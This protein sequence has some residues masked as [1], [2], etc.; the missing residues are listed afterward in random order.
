MKNERDPEHYCF[1]GRLRALSKRIA[2]IFAVLVAI[3]GLAQAAEERSIF[4]TGLTTEC[5][6]FSVSPTGELLVFDTAKL[7][8]GTRLINLKTGAIQI[9]P[10]ESGRN[11]EMVRWASDGKRLVGIS[12]LV[13]DNNYIVEDQRVILIDPRDWS[14]RVIASGEGVKIFPFFS[15][16]DKRIYYFKGKARASGKTIAAGFDLFSVDV[17]SGREEKQTN[18]SFYQVSVG[19]AIKGGETILFSSFGG[20]NFMSQRNQYVIDAVLLSFD[21][22]SKRLMPLIIKSAANTFD[23][24][25]PK[26][27]NNGVFYFKAAV[28]GNQ[29]YYDFSVFKVNKI[30]DMPMR[31]MNIPNWAG[32]EIT[33]SNGDV[34]FPDLEQGK[35]VFRRIASTSFGM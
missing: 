17:V 12:T 33:R 30:G 32:F 15:A 6:D 16:D 25:R 18:E 5:R 28:K 26:Q 31:L 3:Y 29:L 9:L 4:R 20:K 8:H 19:D 27:D 34:Y 7:A 21:T 10:S 23:F 14:H 22:R 13:R 35:L 1:S 24:S 11:W 2:L